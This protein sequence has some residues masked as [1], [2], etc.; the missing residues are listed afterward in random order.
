MSAPL[1]AMLLG[2]S[3]ILAGELLRLLDGHSALALEAVFS[4]EAGRPLRELHPQ[5]RSTLA[6]SAFEEAPELVARAARTGAGELALFLSLPHGESATTWKRLRASLGAAAEGVRVVDLSADYR[7]RDGALHQRTYGEQHDPEGAGEFVYGL[8]ELW[9]G[10]VR[11]ARR[12]AAAG[13]FA[14]ALQLACLPAAAEKLLDATRP[15]VFHGVTGSSGAGA[16]PKASTHHPFRHGNLFA[17]GVEGHRHEAE[18]SQALAEHGLEPE[19]C[20]LPHSGPFARGIHLSAALPL[21]RALTSEEARALYARR[22]AGERFVEVL[23]SGVPELRSVVGSNRASLALFAR[24]RTLIVLLALDNMVK[25]GAGQ[26]LQCMNL[27]LGLPEGAGL[28]AV[29]TGVA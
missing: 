11:E 15:W 20:F 1:R 26:A 22:Y 12:V 23:A 8:P 24:G 28:S 3:G 17:Y 27:M 13:C 16:T 18:L 14:T 4:R 7:L 5:L 10:R 2:G 6:T 19:L 29:G 9:R 25:G 21:A